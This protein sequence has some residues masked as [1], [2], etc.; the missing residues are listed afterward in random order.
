M[1]IQEIIFKILT[2]DPQLW[3]RYSVTKY[4]ISKKELLEFD[5]EQVE[6]KNVIVPHSACIILQEA[7][8]KLEFIKTEKIDSEVYAHVLFSR[9][10]VNANGTNATP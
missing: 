4:S 7:G 8:F 5:K 9:I 6:I 2:T 3:L 10:Y 1:N